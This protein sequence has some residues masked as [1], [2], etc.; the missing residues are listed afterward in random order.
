MTR[1]PAS[2][3]GSVGRWGGRDHDSRYF[4]A[5]FSVLGEPSP[6]VSWTAVG[7][8]SASFSK[9]RPPSVY[10]RTKWSGATGTE[11]RRD[12]ERLGVG[13]AVVSADRRTISGGML[14]SMDTVL[15]TDRPRRRARGESFR[16]GRHQGPIAT[17]SRPGRHRLLPLDD[18][19]SARSHH[20]VRDGLRR[21][22]RRFP[23][24]GDRHGC[25][26]DGRQVAT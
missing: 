2:H 8:P 11:G 15:Q 17:R 16:R 9:R 25:G 14:G 6:M 19:T 21:S 7:L 23:R 24:A 3:L 20:P 13:R 26:R 1:S 5:R 10:G 4:P 18:G 22:N 12:P